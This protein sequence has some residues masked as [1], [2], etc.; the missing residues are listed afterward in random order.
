MPKLPVNRIKAVIFDLDN[1][2]VESQIDYHQ[3]KLDVLGELAR[4]GVG[5]SLLSPSKTIMENIK[6]GKEDLLQKRPG[7]D[8]GV[9]DDRLNAL[10]TAR[11]ME[12]V[13]TVKV[14]A[15]AC[16]AL[17]A[18]RVE[19]MAVGVLTRGSR[20]YALKV[21]SL[22]GL[23]SKVG[24]C[25]CRDDYPLEEA[26]PNPLAMIRVA[27]QVGLSARDCLYVGDHPM[28]FDCANASGASFVGVMTGSTDGE[29]WKK[30]GCETVIASVADLPMI[31]AK[32]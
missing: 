25:V 11:E 9:I 5:P 8:V 28:D 32:L 10:L 6:I 4:S 17:D 21:L 23:D 14:H 15:G 1:T 26:K 27:N 20:A 22:T 7:M 30:S 12:R 13:E 18:V 29:R 3:M 31:L 2:L 19:D 16:E 24:P